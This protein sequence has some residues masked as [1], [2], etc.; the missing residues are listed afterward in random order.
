MRVKDAA[1]AAINALPDEAS[2]DDVVELFALMA[3]VEKGQTASRELLSPK[4][5]RSE[6]SGAAPVDQ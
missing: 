4:V 5:E 3:A 1:H 2:F 6:F